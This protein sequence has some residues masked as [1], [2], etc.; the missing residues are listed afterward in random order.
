[1]ALIECPECGWEVSDTATV[2]PKCAYPLGTGTPAKPRRA[3]SRLQKP[4]W[5]RTA[6]SIVGRL[7]LGGFLAGIGGGEEESVAAVIGGLIIVASAIP[8]FYRDTIERLKAGQAAST[9]DHRVEDRIS[10]LEQRQQEQMDR[11][12]RMHTGQMAESKSAS[13]SR[14]GCSPNSESRSV[15]A[16][17]TVD[18]A[19][20]AE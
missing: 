10:E 8:V 1:M 2:C 6:I 13:S 9:L 5:W 17:P 20:E 15:P 14:S 19:P 4:R 7:A 11:L 16:S 3:V 18:D 12:E